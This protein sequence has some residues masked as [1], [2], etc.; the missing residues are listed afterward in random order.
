MPTFWWGMRCRCA[1]FLPGTTVHNIELRPGKGA[2][3]VR[4]AG[5]S[6]QLVAKEGDYALVKL[7]SGETRKVLQD[8]MATIGQVGQHG[9]RERDQG[10]GGTHALGG[11]VVRTTA[12]F[13]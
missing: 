9:S 4:S 7:P 3:M 11:T 1:T 2:Q 12:A 6:A 8:C 5:G 10:Q 13:R